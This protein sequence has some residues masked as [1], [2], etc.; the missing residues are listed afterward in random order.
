MG[1]KDYVKG[2]LEELGTVHFGKVL[3]KPGKPL[4]F[5]TLQTEEQPAQAEAGGCPPRK[6]FFF[7]LPGNPVSSAVTFNLIVA[8]VLRELVAGPQARR[9]DPGSDASAGGMCH[10]RVHARLAQRLDLDPARPEYHRATLVWAAETGSSGTGCWRANSTG[11]QISSKLTNMLGASVL[12]ELPQGG[13]RGAQGTVHD[14]LPE[15]AWVSCILIG[16]WPENVNSHE[17]G[18]NRQAEQHPGG[19]VVRSGVC[20]RVRIGVLTISD[21]ASS[22]A[23]EDISG[24]AIISY[25]NDKLASAPA[26]ATQQGGDDSAA[27]EFSYRIIPDEQHVIESALID[28]CDSARCDIVVTTGGTGARACTAHRHDVCPRRDNSFPARARECGTGRDSVF[29]LTCRILLLPKCMR[30]ALCCHNRSQAPRNA[31]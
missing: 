16:S 13:Q 1:D 4:T 19:S 15:G 5:A 3:M 28:L 23:Y 14:H 6:M 20:E 11:N 25:M 24:P 7:G 8:P 29:D 18:V 17:S 31:M 21:R 10:Q 12:I 2:V 22:G 27:H 26:D 9:F 30:V